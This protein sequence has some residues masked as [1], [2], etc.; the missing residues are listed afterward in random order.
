MN[1]KTKL[2]LLSLFM[3]FSILQIQVAYAGDETYWNDPTP[4]PLGTGIDVTG[5]CI[6][7][8]S[9]MQTWPFPGSVATWSAPMVGGPIVKSIE[10][11]AG[12]TLIIQGNY[13]LYTGPNTTS[14]FVKFLVRQGGTLII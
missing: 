6:G 11:P 14:P 2:T 7:S 13:E 8:I 4:P 12:K 10:I 5:S 3:A 9:A 1:L